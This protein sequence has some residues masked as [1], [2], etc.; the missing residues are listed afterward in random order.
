MVKLKLTGTYCGSVEKQERSGLLLMNLGTNS[1]APIIQTDQQDDKVQEYEDI[2]KIG[3]MG[4][5]SKI[6]IKVIQGMIQ[7]ERPINWS[8]NNINKMAIELKNI[9][10]YNAKQFLK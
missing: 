3:N 10:I 8:I 6:K 7:L 9:E 4:L 1:N 5:V 2:F